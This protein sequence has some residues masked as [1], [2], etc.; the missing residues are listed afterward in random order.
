VIA[1]RQVWKTYRQGERVVHALQDVSLT[2]APGE[3]VALI[4]PSGAGKSTLLSLL[5]LMDVPSEGEVILAGKPTNTL[6]DAARSNLR[7][8]EIGF[9]FQSF[10]LIAELNAW[11]N[12]ALPLKY[13][14]VSRRERRERALDMLSRVGLADRAEHRPAELSGGQEQ[15]VAIARALIA[16]PSLV[17]ADEPTGNLDSK[18]SEQILQLLL[19]VSQDQKTLVTVTHSSDV[20]ALMQ[21]QISILDGRLQDMA[22]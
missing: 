19:A 17:L 21:R 22:G 13:L 9:V 4:G 16:E 14:G 6:S 10:N 11:Q 15:R 8:H 3:S 20:A 5:G 1:L 18:T 12:V 2:L 7:G